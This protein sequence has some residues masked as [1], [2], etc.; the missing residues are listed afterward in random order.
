M[1]CSSHHSEEI[2]LRLTIHCSRLF[3]WRGALASVTAA[4][5]GKFSNPR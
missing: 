4:E 2:E 1:G 5:L 3:P